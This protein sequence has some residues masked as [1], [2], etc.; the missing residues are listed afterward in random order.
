MYIYSR[1][2]LLDGRY[3]VSYLSRYPWILAQELAYSRYSVRFAERKESG[4]KALWGNLTLRL[5]WPGKLTEGIFGFCQANSGPST[6]GCQFFITCS[7]CDWLDGKHV[8]FGES[9]SC[10]GVQAPFTQS[11]T[12]KGASPQ[13]P[14]PRVPTWCN[15]SGSSREGGSDGRWRELEGRAEGCV[16]SNATTWVIRMSGVDPD[17]IT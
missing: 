15:C 7:K 8:V 14:V 12:S 13:T 5:A 3:C 4:L 1:I 6:N 16:M 11:G 17:G 10:P 2:W 9:Y